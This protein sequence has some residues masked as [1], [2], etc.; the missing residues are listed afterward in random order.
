MRTHSL[1]RTLA[2]SLVV[3]V[4]AC[5]PAIA[6]APPLQAGDS[7]T[8]E[9]TSQMKLS[10]NVPA[11]AAGR[12]QPAYHATTTIDVKSVNPDGSA[13]V[14]VVVKKDL[15]DG[16]H[17]G[18]AQMAAWNQMNAG[19][20][21]DTTM[22][23]WRALRINVDIEA[24]NGPALSGSAAQESAQMVA[25]GKDPNHQHA[26]AANEAKGYLSTVDAVAEACAKRASFAPGDTW[27]AIIDGLPYDFAVTG[28]QTEGARDV[29]VLSVAYDWVNPGGET[30]LN[31]TALYDPKA[32]LVVGTHTATIAS[33]KANG[34]TSTTTSDTTLKE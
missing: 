31:G 26:V 13:V 3:A 34:M 21:F 23:P 33:I 30:K 8:Y 27:H 15:P 17:F 14:H 32:Q 9:T 16:I 28:R 11:Q 6:A 25:L 4:A 22:M 7:L 10:G 18:A 5:L 12:P 1:V 2:T 24:F 19:S 20:E 29:V